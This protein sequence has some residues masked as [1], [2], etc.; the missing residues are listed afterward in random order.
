MPN[1][2][3]IRAESGKYADRF[4]AGGYAGI[5]WLETDDLSAVTDRKGLYP[6][7]KKDN[8]KDP[9]EVVGQQVGQIARFRFEIEPGDYVLTPDIDTE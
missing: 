7:Y 4:V 9:K 5:G 8:P 3:C 1:L 2:Y 6:L